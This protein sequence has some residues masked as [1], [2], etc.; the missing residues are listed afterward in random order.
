MSSRRAVYP[1]VSEILARKERG[2]RNL[3]SLPFAEKIRILEAMRDRLELFRR[4]REGRV[5]EAERS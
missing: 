2:R 1:D 4:L 5:Q 3:A